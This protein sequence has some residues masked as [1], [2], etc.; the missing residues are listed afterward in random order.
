M[1][2]EKVAISLFEGD[3]R[4][5]KRSMNATYWREKEINMTLVSSKNN[6]AEANETWKKNK[7][8]NTRSQALNDLICSQIPIE[9]KDLLFF[10]FRL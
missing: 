2:Y 4:K 3:E 8:H 10:G 1:E 6:Y 9:P 5:T 7:D